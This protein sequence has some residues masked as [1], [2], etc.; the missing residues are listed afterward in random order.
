MCVY[1]ILMEC[2][3]CWYNGLNA[4]FFVCLKSRG[5]VM[6]RKTEKIK[7]YFYMHFKLRS[8]IAIILSMTI[9]I[10][11]GFIWNGMLKYKILITGEQFGSIAEWFSGTVAAI[12]VCLSLYLAFGRRN[13][14]EVY[15]SFDEVKA[16]NGK[17]VP[18]V[19]VFTAYNKSDRTVPLEFYGVRKKK[20]KIFNRPYYNSKHKGK[21]DY[22]P[23]RIHSG[24]SL[25]FPYSIA[26][27][28]MACDLND[29]V[30]ILEFCFA[31]PDGRKHIERF[32][33][34][35]LDLKFK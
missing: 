24:E 25:K 7:D 18:G 10:C 35:N 9:G 1:R 5:L 21:I 28:S 29:Y 8:V 11:I 14:V 6:N 23:Q 13:K 19:I 22:S 15:K 3:M 34:G 20:E 12:G 31:E 30:G 17:N 2:Q 32:K 26:D 4:H 27:F 33:W 16:I